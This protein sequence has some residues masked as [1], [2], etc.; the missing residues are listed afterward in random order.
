M[1]LATLAFAATILSLGA[2]R[3]SAVRS[4][5]VEI[6]F[7]SDAAHTKQVGSV[8][9]LCSGA[10]LKRGRRT[11]YDESYDEP[12]NARLCRADGKKVDCSEQICNRMKEPT[13]CMG[14]V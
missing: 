14:K 13:K 8:T 3:A 12:C 11:A 6:V 5:R 9:F 2:G 4:N 7:F 1:R 10:V